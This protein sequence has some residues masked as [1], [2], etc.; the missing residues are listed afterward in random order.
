M[1]DGPRPIARMG[2]GFAYVN[3]IRE[4]P[5]AVLRC[6]T[7]CFSVDAA[8]PHSLRASSRRR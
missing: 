2:E 8:L 7:L 6:S 4:L 3:A 5:T 1:L